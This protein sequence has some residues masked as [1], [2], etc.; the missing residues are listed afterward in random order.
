MRLHHRYLTALDRARSR[1][2]ILAVCE[3]TLMLNFVPLVSNLLEN[4]HSQLFHL[5]S[6]RKRPSVRWVEYCNCDYKGG[7]SYRAPV[8]KYLPY[9]FIIPP[10]SAAPQPRRP[11]GQQYLYNTGA[12]AVPHF[13]LQHVHHQNTPLSLSLASWTAFRG[14]QASLL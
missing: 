14:Q 8:F 11:D 4:V 5:L 9:V 6:C 13:M 1:T 10:V 12:E 3:L 7:V 2:M